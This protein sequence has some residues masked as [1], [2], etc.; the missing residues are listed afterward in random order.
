MNSDSAEDDGNFAGWADRADVGL[1]LQCR[2]GARK[3]HVYFTKDGR[4]GHT[5]RAERHELAAAFDYGDRRQQP[6]HYIRKRI[7][8]ADFIGDRRPGWRRIG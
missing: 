3:R 5:T 7:A 2:Y 1:V 6:D 8:G 4:N